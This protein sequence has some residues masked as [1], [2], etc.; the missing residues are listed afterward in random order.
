MRIT[1]LDRLVSILAYFTFGIF[2]VIWFI[3]ASVTKKNISSYLMFNL[4]QAIF[5]SVIFAVIGL[6]YG[7]AIDLMS[8]IPFIGKLVLAFDAFFNRTPLYFSFTI[9]GF[10]VTLVVVYLS[11]LSLIGKKP[12]I[13]LVSD[14]VKSN[15]GE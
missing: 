6:V 2:S 8:V 10:I 9:S 14:V 3:F 4:Y 15:F 1:F 5:I 11:V 13:P 12:Y 7:I